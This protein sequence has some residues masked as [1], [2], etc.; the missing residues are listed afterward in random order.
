M[1]TL[2]PAIKTYAT[3]QLEVTSPHI[4]YVEECGNPD[5]VPVLV[6]HSGPGDGCEPIHRRFFDPQLFR[7]VIFDQRGAGRSEPHLELE[8]NT[9]PDLISDIEV[10]REHL[11]IN[12]WVVFGHGWGS[13]LSLLYAQAYPN[14]VLTL[15]LC[16]V[17]LARES[18]IQWFYQHGTNT[19]FPDYWDDF[20]SHVSVHERDDVLRAYFQRLSGND[21][22]QRMATAK[23]WALWQARC[24]FLDPSQDSIQTCA[25][26]RHALSLAVIE[27]Y[28]FHNRCFIEENAI[29]NNMDKIQH[30]PGYI[31]HGRYNI[32]SPLS[33]A[34]ELHRHWPVAQMYTIRDAGHAIREPGLVDAIVL[35]SK[36]IA[37]DHGALA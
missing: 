22:L 13:A 31:I 11:G 15:L 7:I 33:N 20:I 36:A 16:S 27:S 34:W 30:I 19:V 18:D 8:N 12:Q 5:G 28:F 14:H 29:L 26:P 23:A 2:Y 37:K 9:T 21:D 6:L 24:A 35:A 3:H 1:L 32:V 4:L 25:D 10:I 17:F